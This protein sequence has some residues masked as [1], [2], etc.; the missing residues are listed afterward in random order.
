MET[1]VCYQCK[2]PAKVRCAYCLL[3]VCPEHS[4]RVTLWF[5]SQQRLVCAPCQ[6][7]LRDIEHEVYHWSAI[8]TDVSYR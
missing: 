6:A 4:G 7:R 2:T 3:P 5:S 1:V 8:G